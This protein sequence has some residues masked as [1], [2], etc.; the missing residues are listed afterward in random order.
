MP[1]AKNERRSGS[2]LGLRVRRERPDARARR[3]AI[4]DDRHQR[5]QQ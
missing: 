5:H 4:D 3:A 1:F 2:L